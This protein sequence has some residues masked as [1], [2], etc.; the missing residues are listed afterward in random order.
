MR[1]VAVNV[2]AYNAA[3]YRVAPARD[4][5]AGRAGADQS[6]LEGRVTSPPDTTGEELSVCALCAASAGYGS[7]FWPRPTTRIRT[8]GPSV[9]SGRVG[10]CC[11]ADPRWLCA[12]YL[13]GKALHV[14][15][16][17]AGPHRRTLEGFGSRDGLGPRVRGS[18]IGDQTTG[19]GVT[20]RWTRKNEVG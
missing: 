10:P 20:I 19:Y 11:G 18:L 3:R 2:R 4:A 7:G 13:S 14:V 1:L 16:R 15:L 12:P 5:V 8:T 6:L 17:D 9:G